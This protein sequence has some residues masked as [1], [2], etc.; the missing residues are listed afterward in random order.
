MTEGIKREHFEERRES[1]RITTE[2]PITIESTVD[3]GLNSG[4]TTNIS[5][6]GIGFVLGQPLPFSTK[7]SL[8]LDIRSQQIQSPLQLAWSNKDERGFL[9]GGRFANIKKDQ[10]GI[11]KEV[12]WLNED[13]ITQQLRPIIKLLDSQPEIK[14]KVVDFFT[15]DAK[16]YVAQILAVKRNKDRKSP[17]EQKRLDEMCN[18]IVQ[19][20]DEAEKV[21][22]NKQIVK[23]L[24]RKFRL[25]TG[26]WVYQSKLMK[27]AFEKPR[28]YPG[29]YKMIETIYEN[30]PVSNGIGF[31]FDRY[32]LANPYA[33]AVRNRKDKMVEILRNFL[34]ETSLPK[35]K[36]LNLAC[37]SCREIKELFIAPLRC[38]ANLTFRCVDHDNR[39]LEF[40]RKSLE[41]R[42]SYVTVKF[43]EENILNYC[44]APKK[45]FDLLGEQNLIYSLGLADY[46]SDGILKKLLQFSYH[47]LKPR[48]KLVITHK[49]RSNDEQAP[50]PPAWFCDWNFVS[51]D[52]DQLLRLAKSVNGNYSVSMEREASQKIIFLTLH[53]NSQ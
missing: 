23:T 21:V 2:I 11:L 7:V 16:N 26:T 17:Y 53:K 37:G 29:D 50:L 28:N 10:L 40:A 9:Y 44:R 18:K 20:G 38:Q 45:Y 5:E 46:L 22:G 1:P 6:A 51:R 24:K 4:K 39:A 14:E 52:A 48:G 42:P 49:D 27:R 25:M 33:V 34:E 35:V 31:Y 15:K 32:F 36:V 41:T 30:R 13:F 47:L 8:F 3:A 43:L 19:K 12:L